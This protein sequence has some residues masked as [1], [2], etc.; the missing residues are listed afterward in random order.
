[1]KRIA[2]FIL[3]IL[4][5]KNYFSQLTGVITVPSASFTSIAAVISALNQQGSSGPL[6]VNITSGYTETAPLGGYTLTASGTVTAPITF[7]KSGNAANPLITAYSGGSGTPGSMNQDGIWRLIGSDFVTIDRIDLLDTNSV[8][9]ATMEFGYGLFKSDAGNGCWNTTIKNCTITLNRINNATGSGPAMDGSRGIDVV[10]AVTNDHNS[11]ITVTAVAGSHSFNK[12]YG[13]TIRNCNQAVALIGYADSAPYTLS[14]QGNE[15]GG[16]MISDGNTI[17]D[18]GGGGT[19]T[20]SAAIRTLAQYN[21]AVQFNTIS[22]NTGLGIN[23]AATLRGIYLGNAV[24]A[25]ATIR[26]NTITLSGGG[27]NN[28]VSV[29]E[30]ISG[31]GAVSNTISI[32]NNLIQNCSY[33]SAVSPAYYGIW[34]SASPAVLSISNNSFVNNSSHASGGSTY[35]ISNTGA[36]TNSILIMH[37]H[38]GFVFSGSA[39]YNGTMYFV[40]NS[41]GTTATNL[42]I[43][44]ND[45]SNQYYLYASGGGNL[46]F[47]RNTNDS[48]MLNFSNN[49]FTQLNLDHS[50]SQYL[51]YN[52]SATQSVLT[53]CNN[54]IIGMY[55]R[56][57]S[58][59]PMYG[60]YANGNSPASSTH[61][62]NAN[63]FSNITSTLS[64]TGVFYGIHSTDGSSS[65]YPKKIISNNVVSNIAINSSG[66]FYAYYFDKLGDAA[67]TNSSEVSGNSV[68]GIS[69]AGSIYG[70]YLASAASPSYAVKILENKFL[71][72]FTNGL[73][74][75]IYGAYISNAGAGVNFYKNKLS[76]A[77]ATGTAAISHGVYVT[78]VQSTTLSNNLIGYLNTPNSFA[79][80]ALNGIYINSGSRVHLF[81]NTVY[82]NATSSGGNFNSNALYAS[83]TVSVDLRNS[84][85]INTSSG[86]SGTT[87]VYRRSSTSLSTYSSSSNNNLFY[88]GTPSSTNV[89]LQSGSTAYQTVSSMQTALSPREAASVTQ[90]VSFLSLN[91][92][93][94]NYLHVTPHVFAFTESGALNIS[95]ITDDID[96]QTRQGNTGYLGNGTNPDIGADEFEMNLS[97]CT[98]AHAGTL[99][100]LS[101]SVCAGQTISLLS[102]GYTPG[103]V[104]THQWKVSTFS[105]GPYT[106]V[107]SGS[108]FTTPEYFSA[109]L[110]SGVYYFILETTCS[111]VSLTAVTQQATVVVNAIPSATAAV[112][113]NLICAGQNLLLTGASSLSGTFSWL[114]PNGFYSALQSPTLNNSSSNAAGNYTL[115]V[116]A[117]N[118]LSAPSTISVNI[119]QITLSLTASPQLICSGNSSTLSALSS[120]TTFTW[121]NGANGSS[122][123]VSP[124]SSSVYSVAVTNTAFCTATK[125]ITLTLISPTI[126]TTGAVL[127]G[128][129]GSINLSVNAFTPSLVNWFSSMSSSMSVFTGT[130]FSVNAI[131]DTTFFVE[132]L[133]TSGACVS[134]RI[135]VSLTVSPYPT[136][137]VTSN[138]QSV[139][140]GK[141]S[142]LSAVGANTYSWVGLGT[143]SNRTVNPISATTY[144][145]I[146]KNM[147]GCATTATL[148]V[149][150]YP[151]PTLT[152][153]QS[154]TSVCPSS[155]L[156]FTA[157]GAISY[158]WNT[159]AI[160]T[161][162]T[163]TPATN[164]TYTVYG[165]NAEGCVSSKTLAVITRSVPLITIY[166]SADSLCPGEVITFT[167]TGANSYTWL[168]GGLISS[169]FSA[170]PFIS[171]VYNAIGSSV[172]SCTQVS[173][174]MVTVD[175]CTNVHDNDEF[176][177]DLHIFPNP[178]HDQ[179][180]IKFNHKGH[181]K[182][183]M[184]SSIGLMILEKSTMEELETIY[185]S[186]YSKGVYFIK[187]AQ[188]ENFKFFKV[189]VD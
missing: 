119:S 145:V 9:P 27:I 146:G 49:T 142:S 176:L 164:S 89:I 32:Q 93:S 90:S 118:C 143:G 80:N 170:S 129:S 41:N 169:T 71:N 72:V 162:T 4:I 174:V 175:P 105:S 50:G 74:S 181:K 144:T 150:V 26:H 31:S 110:N 34:N 95:G 58:A 55:Q 94:P 79:N 132:A 92:N 3:C 168:P 2:Y 82:L 97:P 22:N 100:A 84:I 53:V 116:S 151:L 104:L 158:T 130:T 124:T 21:L 18:F 39:A 86:G 46:F 179:I 63:N 128:N 96:S 81:Y 68:S 83:T 114:G 127:C 109:P 152:A 51:I 160:G 85:L 88:A 187:V 157:S 161:I 48:Y 28:Q 154:A 120:A 156:G 66:I 62:I 172:N 87:A 115:V 138:P 10:N 59:G 136:L 17:L 20:A 45:F 134:P 44:H 91:S 37:N 76:D 117:N 159:G 180:S 140:P 65:P 38:L 40:N 135:P 185:L 125:Q 131:S 153:Q 78:S 25:S 177:K 107:S 6:I 182:I 101:V 183:N 14:D 8:N 16:G 189:I 5:S 178:T 137:N 13:N 98:S 7:Q 133:H 69:C 111:N 12:F 148:Q 57:A 165:S 36:V 61:L 70:L 43:S 99:S 15:I 102:N 171:S 47:I 24:G 149:T 19:T 35:L 64:G 60:Y 123:V 29:I 141:T 73:S 1:M 30:N 42:T 103:T 52:S 173:F 112:V 67:G 75:S 122:I 33:T 139:C 56:N 186:A 108:G 121:S 106:N 11:A 23:H 54:S 77:L 113:N 155:V 188:E 163:V 184:F 147:F 126:N 166:Q 167:A